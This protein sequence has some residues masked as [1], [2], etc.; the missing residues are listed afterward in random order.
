MKKYYSKRFIISKTFFSSLKW[1]IFTQHS[2][3][4][5]NLSLNFAPNIA[6]E[7]NRR[8]FREKLKTDSIRKKGSD[9]ITTYSYLGLS[10]REF[11][12]FRIPLRKI[13]NRTRFF[14]QNRISIRILRQ[15]KATYLFFWHWDD[16]IDVT[17]LWPLMLEE[18]SDI[19]RP[20]TRLPRLSAG[21]TCL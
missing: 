2:Q 14:A 10:F 5:A 21:P 7:K 11:V 8:T 9:Q 20:A 19:G 18:G 4:R 16:R 17:G 1:S 3:T 6:F 15:S 12:A 13:A